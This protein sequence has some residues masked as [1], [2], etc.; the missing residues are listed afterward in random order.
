MN[1]KKLS[2][3][4]PIPNSM[5]CICFI[6]MYLLGRTYSPFRELTADLHFS[7][8]CFSAAIDFT[9]STSPNNSMY[10]EVIHCKLQNES[11]GNY[12]TFK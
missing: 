4:F 2:R 8:V 10:T 12:K 9:K 1:K 5:D 11:I 6:R 7:C 3:L